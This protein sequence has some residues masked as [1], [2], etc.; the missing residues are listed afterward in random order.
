[1]ALSLSV[2]GKTLDGSPYQYEVV[3]LPMQIKIM[4]A[5]VDA[6]WQVLRIKN[7]VTGDW[8]GEYASAEQ[9]F[10]DIQQFW[11]A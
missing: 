9:A 1:M 5:K 3:G 4:I 2:M 6:R 7:G 11:M 8:T 10:A